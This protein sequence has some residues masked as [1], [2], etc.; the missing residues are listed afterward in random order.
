MGMRQQFTKTMER[1]T[2][3][4]ERVIT[5]LNDIGVFAFRNI[6][7]KHPERVRNLGILEQASIGVAAGLS[8]VGFIPFFHTI[9]P[10][11]VERGYE[12]LKDDFGYQKINGNFISVGAS[13]DYSA[14]GTTH[15]CPADV[16]ALMQIPSMQIIVPGTEEEFDCLLISEYDNGAPSYFRLSEISNDT[17]VDVQFGKANVIRKGKRGTII[18]V[19]TMLDKVLNAVDG[20]DVTVLYYTTIVP[21]DHETLY[22][23]TEINK[24]LLCEP[25]YYGGITNQVV[26]TFSGLPVEIKY[27]GVPHAFLTSYGSVEEIEEE[28]GLTA[29][30]IRQA[31][32]ELFYGR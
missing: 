4:D 25:Y 29:E 5:L 3:S 1:L 27:A 8:M 18:A 19:G 9:A 23:T 24:V 7:A 22:Q 31:A 11:I 6:K 30:R 20:M 32:M 14:L 16:G 10:F 17:S 15:Y 12:Q 13:Y 21:F 26:E 28:I 2:D